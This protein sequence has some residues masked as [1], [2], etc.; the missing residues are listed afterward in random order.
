MSALCL[1]NELR[2]LT[3]L[4][5]LAGSNIYLAFLAPYM[6]NDLHAPVAVALQVG[7]GM[8]FL[9]FL[10]EVPTGRAADRYGRKLSLVIG[11]VCC[12]LGLAMYATASSIG[13]WLLVGA[14]FSLGG[15]AFLSGADSAL[16]RSICVRDNSPEVAVAMYAHYSAQ[17]QRCIAICASAGSLF[18]AL[19]VWR[20]GLRSTLW[21]QSA[22]Y[23]LMLACACWVKSPGELDKNHGMSIV[24]LLRSFPAR[25]KLLA[26]FAFSAAIM[27]MTAM[28]SKLVPLYCA[29]VRVSGE[30]L[31]ASTPGL[32]WAGYTALQSFV[33]PDWTKGFGR[34]FGYYRSFGIIIGV[35][36]VCYLALGLIVS[37]L[38]LV[39][40][41][42]I[43]LGQPL[44]YSRMDARIGLLC[45]EAE[46]ATIMSVNRT[47]RYLV[48]SLSGLVVSTVVR[49]YGLPAG[50]LCAG[51][52]L[53][54]LCSLALLAMIVA[55]EPEPL[56]IDSSSREITPAQT[57]A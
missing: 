14:V 20:F 18:G 36:A 8:A 5:A 10:F 27:A 37:P 38:G 35:G 22:V 3:W 39:V 12:V 2:K 13:P 17:T 43:F 31:P 52:L 21:A 40:V 42:F 33:R 46:H 56:A 50:M 32:L 24:K 16:A 25:R 15:S 54:G 29:N 11:S 9:G 55:G 49:E 44:Q 48:V 47:G 57:G 7:S 28:A 30:H 34:K 41:S 4:R 23:V 6:V 53:G 26:A 19:L 51:G 1:N 45:S